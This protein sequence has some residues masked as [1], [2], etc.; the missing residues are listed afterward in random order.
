[1]SATLDDLSLPHYKDLV[2]FTD[3]AQ[4]MRD[5]EARAIGHE[6]FQ[7]FLN[8]LLGGCVHASG[9]LVQDEDRRIFQ[10][11]ARDAHALLFANA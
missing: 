6:P 1:M 2:G 3:C 7:S 11:R 5:D 10:Q 9:R 8:Q 4:S